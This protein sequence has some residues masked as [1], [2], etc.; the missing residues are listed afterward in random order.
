MDVKSFRGKTYKALCNLNRVVSSSLISVYY[1]QRLYISAE[2]LQ[3][4]TTDRKNYLLQTSERHT[5]ERGLGGI[6]S[7]IKIYHF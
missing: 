1:L 6:R 3:I 7:P 5:L 2:W 4:T